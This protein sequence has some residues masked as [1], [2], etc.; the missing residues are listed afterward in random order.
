M[1]N[2]DSVH[3]VSAVPGEASTGER[4]AQ[5]SCSQCGRELG[6]GPCGMSHCSDH[7]TPEKLAATQA[8]FR[9]APLRKLAA[10]FVSVVLQTPR[11][12]RL[13]RRH[14]IQSQIGQLQIKTG[15]ELY[16]L[17]NSVASACEGS[18]PLPYWRQE[19][20]DFCS[21]LENDLMAGE[22]DPDALPWHIADSI[23]SQR[24][25]I[26]HDW[27]LVAQMQGEGV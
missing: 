13:D 24:M 2:T 19:L 8:M 1:S 23:E 25:Q 15:W 18:D 9:P 10:P 3:S 12:T 6:P 14:A 11:P 7:A 21:K 4:F 27:P 26:D 16:A 20:E 17:L 22:A 5:T